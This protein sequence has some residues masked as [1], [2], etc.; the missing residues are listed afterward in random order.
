MTTTDNWQPLFLPSLAHLLFFELGNKTF[1]TIRLCVLLLLILNLSLKCFYVSAVRSSSALLPS[2]IARNPTDLSLW[3]DERQVMQLSGVRMTIFAIQDG[4][5]A[6]FLLDSSNFDRYLGVVPAEVGAVNFTWR[7]GELRRYFYEFDRL[8]SAR[9]QLLPHP[10]INVALTGLIPIQPRTFQVL[11]PCAEH[12]DETVRSTS[13]LKSSDGQSLNIEGGLVAFELGLRIQ[14]H[15]GQ[16]LPGTPL[17]FRLHKYCA[18]TLAESDPSC[19]RH[20]VHGRC[21]YKQVCRCQRGYIGDRCD[22]ALCFPP[23]QHGGRCVRPGQCECLAG[24]QGPHCEGGLCSQRCENGGKCVQKD[25]C[26]CS[27]GHYGSR[28]SFS[29]CSLPCLNGGRCVG[30]DQC[31]CRRSFEGEQCENRKS[32][33]PKLNGER[34]TDN[35]TLETSR[36]HKKPIQYV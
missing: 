9:P 24:F 12:V 17:R 19:D 33:L 13:E 6:S 20:C 27:A 21:D 11:L 23:C 30:V 25:R 22:Q 5:L 34:P 3:I 31:R 14:D 18:S 8:H 35:R 26:Q 2:A 10:T 28:C 1:R 36:S 29:L 32:V 16:S 4:Q 7:G 15:E